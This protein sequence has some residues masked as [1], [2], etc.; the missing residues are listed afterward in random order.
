ME[1]QGSAAR[2]GEYFGAAIVEDADDPAILAAAIDTALGIH[3]DI[4]RTLY[5]ADGKTIRALQQFIGSRY[6]SQR[7]WFGR[8]I[9]RRVNRVRN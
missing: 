9:G 4:F 2:I 8:I 5:H 1:S 3:V 7:R 6:S